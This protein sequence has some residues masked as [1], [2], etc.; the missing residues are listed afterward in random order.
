MKSH[1][2]QLGV[3]LLYRLFK[4][5]YVWG[6]NALYLGPHAI[7]RHDEVET[8]SPLLHNEEWSQ[9]NCQTGMVSMI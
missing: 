9:R 2:L 3:Q 4:T 5:L 6:V 7:A 1:T 8:Y